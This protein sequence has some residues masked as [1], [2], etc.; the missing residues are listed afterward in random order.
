MWLGR[1]HDCPGWALG[2]GKPPTARV[3]S[4]VARG[5][6]PLVSLGRARP[7]AGREASEVS[8]VAPV[9]AGCPQT[10][11]PGPR[12]AQE[13]T[14]T[15]RAPRPWG[16]VVAEAV[17][18]TWSQLCFHTAWGV[19][20]WGRGLTGGLGTPLSQLQVKLGPVRPRRPASRQGVRGGRLRSEGTAVTDPA[21]VAQPQCQPPLKRSVLF[22]HIPF[23]GCCF[24][25]HLM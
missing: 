11:S 9:G 6:C 22:R 2:Q 19:A 4:S 12:A 7:G 17:S 5:S 20:E 3:S 10:L 21:L 25:T 18:W 13:G 14:S 24:P 16:Q 1:G 8:P 23:R 15:L